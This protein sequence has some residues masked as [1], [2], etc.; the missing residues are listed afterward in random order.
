MTASFS[1][2]SPGQYIAGYEIEEKLQERGEYLVYTARHVKLKRK[3]LLKI[4]KGGDEKLIRRFER[5]AEI[6]ADIEHPS[7]VSV[8]DFG[9]WEGRF[10]IAMEYVEGHDLSYYIKNRITDT[11]KLTGIFYKIAGALAVIHGKNYIHRDLKPE[12]ILVTAGLDIKIT[13]FGISFHIV[14]QQSTPDGSIKGTPAYLSPEQI[15]NQT[16]TSA[17]DLFALGIIYYELLTG[18]N[19]FLGAGYPETLSRIM[20]YEPPPPESGNGL[21]EI[22]MKLLNKDPRKR[23]KSAEE[24]K[25]ELSRLLPEDEKTAQTVAAAP[26]KKYP[27]IIFTVIILAVIGLLFFA[28]LGKREPETMK[29]TIIHDT[30]LV[31][32]PDS[33]RPPLKPGGVDK[34]T[35]APLPGKSNTSFRRRIA[36]ESSAAKPIPVNFHINPWAVISLNGVPRDT[37]PLKKPLLLTPGKYLLTLENPYFPAW[38]DTIRIE[39]EKKQSFHFILD[40]LFCRLQLQ[41]I[42]WG[43]INIDGRKMGVSPLKNPLLVRR[44]IHR[45][46]IENPYY[47]TWRDTIDVTKPNTYILRVKLKEKSIADKSE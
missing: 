40:S 28:T 45:I 13:D 14:R 21:A 1:H 25:K 19:P 29:P 6:L 46:T 8:Y 37:T 3:T 24:V 38:K 39:P 11:K 31:L 44:G 7:I 30:L 23:Y 32:T 16:V 34:R 2:Q 4:Y 10:F 35:P 36:A 15:S 20:G 47:Q 41:V 9:E 26:G 33:S 17:S 42:P 43:K 27:G 18:N 12:N 5:E 22:I